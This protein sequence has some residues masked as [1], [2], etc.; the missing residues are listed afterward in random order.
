LRNRT[1]ITLFTLAAAE[2]KDGRR[3]AEAINAS[4]IAILCFL[5][6]AARQAVDAIVNPAV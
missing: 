5:D 2:R 1:D 6:T 4:D 3:R